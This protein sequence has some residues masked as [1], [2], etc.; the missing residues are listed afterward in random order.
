[1]LRKHHFQRPTAKARSCPCDSKNLCFEGKLQPLQKR[2]GLFDQ[3]CIHHL[4]AP[5]MRCANTRIIIYLHWNAQYRS[6]RPI[7]WVREHKGS[8]EKT[9]PQ[10]GEPVLVW[11]LPEAAIFRSQSH[12]TKRLEKCML[13]YDRW[14]SAWL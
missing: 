2:Q 10:L 9:F 3:P 13:C 5:L 14:Q 8:K 1:M 12:A 11:I 7:L 6:A 4:P